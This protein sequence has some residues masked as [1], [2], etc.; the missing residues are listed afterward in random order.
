L[1]KKAKIV[2][3]GQHNNVTRRRCRLSNSTSTRISV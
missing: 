1:F 3:E 2:N